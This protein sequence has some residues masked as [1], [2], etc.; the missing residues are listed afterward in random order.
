M[1]HEK[2]LADRL[3]RWDP[4]APYAGEAWP[5]VARDLAAAGDGPLLP[6]RR[7]RDPWKPRYFLD[8][9]FTDFDACQLISMAIVGEN[10]REFYGEC[11]DF[12]HPLCSDF[13]RATVLPQLGQFPDRAMP[14]NQLRRELLDWLNRVPA[15]PTPVL[16]FDF[17]GDLQLVEHLL[18]GPLPRGWKTENIC[19]RLD[20]RR[21]AGYFAEHGGEHHALY[22][23]RAHGSAFI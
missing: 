20:A 23:A 13:V 19:N 17:H 1:A 14:F 12:E 4:A 8:T 18:G 15:K 16:C 7:P 6:D 5:G 2:K 10:G 21:V 22:D 9:E 3:A 11:S